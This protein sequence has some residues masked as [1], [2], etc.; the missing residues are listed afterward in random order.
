MNVV[1]TDLEDLHQVQIHTNYRS[2]NKS[3][4]P[5]YVLSECKV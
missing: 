1:D 2:V 4:D 5:S 3:K